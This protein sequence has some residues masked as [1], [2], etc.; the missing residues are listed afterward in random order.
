MLLCKQKLQPWLWHHLQL[1]QVAPLVCLLLGCVWFSSQIE[2]FDIT[3]FL[4]WLFF[5]SSGY[6]AGFWEYPELKG[7]NRDHWVQLVALHSIT[8]KSDH[9]SHYVWEKTP[10]RAWR[11]RWYNRGSLAKRQ[12]AD[13]AF[14]RIYGE[15]LLPKMVT[16]LFHSISTPCFPSQVVVVL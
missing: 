5:S 3:F 8:E 6:S 14:W 1:C 12:R 2:Y 16:M 7:T 13:N 10:R 4:S 9:G 15:Y 11:D